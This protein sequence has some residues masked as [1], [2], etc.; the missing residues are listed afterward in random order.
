MAE[1]QSEGASQ[2]SEVQ[3]ILEQ[4]GG[5]GHKVFQAA[6]IYN[7]TINHFKDGEIENSY[8]HTSRSLEASSAE[9]E[10]SG[11]TI[12]EM[13]DVPKSTEEKMAEEIAASSHETVL[14][15]ALGTTGSLGSAGLPQTSRE[16]ENW[17]YRDLQERERCFVNACAILHGCTL[18]AITEA[19]REISAPLREKSQESAEKAR[20]PRPSM[21]PDPLPTWMPD[22]LAW[23]YAL[24]QHAERIRNMQ[25]A[26]APVEDIS[27]MPFQDQ[28]PPGFL[29]SL[30]EKT[31][32]YTLH[33][34]GALRVFWEGTEASGFSQFS[35]DVLHFLAREA[36]V[37]GMFGAQT[38][39]HLL[40]IVQQWPA[41]YR[42]AR[43][44]RSARAL[45]IIWWYQ[46]ARNVLS[47]Q[48]N[49]WVKSRSRQDWYLAAALLEGA[50]Q[51]EHD[52]SGAGNSVVLQVLERWISLAHQATTKR[53]EGYAAAR[54]YTLIGRKYPDI[55]LQGL[56]Q[57][58][59]F[60]AASQP[61]HHGSSNPLEDLFIFS[62]VKYVDIAKSGHLRAVLKHL[63]HGAQLSMDAR[64]SSLAQ[65]GKTSQSAPD[66]HTILTAFFLVTSCS[67]SAVDPA[68]SPIYSATQLLPENP[69]FPDK[70]GRDILL[71]G[72]LTAAEP[73]WQDQLAL[74]LC[75]VIMSKGKGYQAAIYLLSRWGEIVCT[76]QSAEDT[77][78][79]ELYAQF[80]IQ[81]GT[82][83]LRQSAGQRQTAIGTYTYQLSL[84]QTARK[85]PQPAFRNLAQRVLGQLPQSM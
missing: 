25:T 38:E 42:G 63:A 82:M 78:Y 74:L 41:K 39:Q 24:G 19:T 16:I 15:N 8:K 48:A 26:P 7:I 4:L 58:L 29:Q 81:I 61:G 33:I 54:A 47:Q 21:E 32:T 57:L 66:L 55:A 17:Y 60:P 5:T 30:L 13:H 22:A 53:G 77:Q 75:S 83:I 27:S 18:R 62:V 76:Y 59:R 56:D 11:E 37:Q 35:I 3:N 28:S 12:D 49:K 80:L 64:Q 67:L 23:S 69:V 84:W 68:L 2:T 40:D 1:E 50:Y 31:H 44:W 34:N 43:A 9:D 52:L 36:T 46:D 20:M 85:L 45:G 6:A 72:L 71:A 70:R 10:E 65:G 51:V 14:E 79:Q 73:D